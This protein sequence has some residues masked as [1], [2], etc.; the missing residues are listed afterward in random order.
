MG[1]YSLM[2]TVFVLGQNCISLGFPILITRETA[3]SPIN[4]SQYYINSC[5][6][7]IGL[8]SIILIFIFP[9]LYIYTVDTEMLFSMCLI[10]LALIPSVFTMYA[11]SVL[12]GLERAE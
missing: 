9:A 5:I 6:V 2:T 3:K 1:K 11:E 10:L 12:L 7:S 4:A 8:L